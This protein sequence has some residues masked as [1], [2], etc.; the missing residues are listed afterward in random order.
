MNWYVV[1]ASVNVQ[2]LHWKYS[3]A[4]FLFVCKTI[5]RSGRSPAIFETYGPTR[6][7]T[8]ERFQGLEHMCPVNKAS[9]G[10]FGKKRSLGFS[11]S[12]GTRGEPDSLRA[13]IHQC[14][15]LVQH[16]SQS[17]PCTTTRESLP[18]SSFGRLPFRCL[19][20]IP[21]LLYLR[22]AEWVALTQWR[23]HQPPQLQRTHL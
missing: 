8:A 18:L 5:P 23:R 12:G 4:Y 14:G 9:Q 1:W 11:F 16:T 17:W 21:P 20:L 13:H 15:P 6:N 19:Y 2:L 7:V 22:Y 10:R 3:S